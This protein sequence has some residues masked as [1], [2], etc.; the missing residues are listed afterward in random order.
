[1]AIRRRVA[2]ALIVLV[3]VVLLPIGPSTNGRPV[4]VSDVPET[5]VMRQELLSHTLSTVHPRNEN[6]STLSYS[7]HYHVRFHEATELFI[8]N[9]QVTPDMLDQYIMHSDERVPDNVQF[10]F[11][12]STG[13]IQLRIANVTPGVM[14]IDTRFTLRD[15]HL[16]VQGGAPVTTAT[17]DRFSLGQETEV[18]IQIS[19]FTLSNPGNLSSVEIWIVVT[20][21]SYRIS[22][23]P[24]AILQGTT[25]WKAGWLY[26]ATYYPKKTTFD[27]HSARFHLSVP[28]K[29]TAAR[30]S[31][32]VV[33][34][35]VDVFAD[36]SLYIS[37]DPPI[38]NT[39]NVRFSHEGLRYNY[40]TEHRIQLTGSS[41][42]ILLAVIMVGIALILSGGTWFATRDQ[43]R[44]GVV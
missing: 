20:R 16:F 4:V 9:D 2:L 39:E 41:Q 31:A 28:L 23:S 7:I 36:G 24:R 12:A 44:Q 42:W 8:I 5:T 6:S 13:Q 17:P 40:E 18:E 33:S 11:N 26:E 15:H 25:E 22:S 32:R 30:A 27:P 14:F 3:F 34:T 10:E 29:W 37:P 19:P 21:E 38:G 35:V 1:V 43:S